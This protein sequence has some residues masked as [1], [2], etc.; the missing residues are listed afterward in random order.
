MK[1]VSYNS[2]G[3]IE[4]LGLTELNK[5]E[6]LADEVLIKIKAVSINPLDWKIRK[7]EMK[8]MSGS[9][10]PKKIGIDFSGSVEKVGPKVTLFKN[11][12]LVFG[13]VNGMKEGALGEYVIVK[14]SQLFQKPEN[15]SFSQAASIPVVGAGAFDAIYNL[16]K[17]KAGKQV[18]I[19]GATGGMGMFAL[20]LA[21]QA[22]AIVTAVANT[23]GIKLA[24]DWGADQVIDYTK[25]NIIETEKKFDVIFDLSGRLNFKN[26]KLILTKNGIFI[27][28]IPV[29]VQI[30]TSAIANIFSVQKNKI[31]LSAVNKVAMDGILAAVKKGLKIEVSKTFPFDDFKKAY[32]Y[33]EKGKYFGKV[34][35]EL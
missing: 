28:P 10:F 25:I 11:E 1:I 32:E 5:P 3:G 14:E 8:L 6:P 34:T 15:L 31:L 13:A 27:N 7:G 4:K 2:F 21:K 18:L 12:D 23:D 20:Q 35:I 19:N 22:G 33:C 24:L 17:V 16:G 30:I 26:T 29:P 9:K